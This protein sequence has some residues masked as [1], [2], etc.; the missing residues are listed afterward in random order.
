MNNYRRERAHFSNSNFTAREKQPHAVSCRFPLFHAA[1]TALPA[2]TGKSLKNFMPIK[3]L[4]NRL[5]S[6]LFALTALQ[7]SISLLRERENLKNKENRKIE[8]IRIMAVE[9]ISVGMI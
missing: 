3:N 2:S 1:F 9:Y 4:I 8:C 7:A 5:Y 6:M